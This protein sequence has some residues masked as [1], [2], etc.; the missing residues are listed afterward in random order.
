[1]KRRFH[2]GYQDEPAVLFFKRGRFY[3]Y[4]G[5]KKLTVDD[6]VDFVKH[7]YRE[8]KHQGRMPLIPTFW[9]EIEHFWNME[10]QIKGGFIQGMLFMDEDT[11]RVGWGGIF[12]CYLFPLIIVYI[13]Y[14]MMSSTFG[15]DEELVSRVVE[16]EQKNE[17]TKKR[18]RDWLKSHPNYI[19]KARKWE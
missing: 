13:Y 7:S 19:K 11:G 16:L 4:L 9:Q 8:T 5:H 1:M 6:M 18:M 2:I 12:V 17:R 15:E 10:V 14:L 3:K